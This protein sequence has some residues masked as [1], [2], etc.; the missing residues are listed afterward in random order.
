MNG[1]QAV[2]GSEGPDSGQI[3]GQVEEDPGGG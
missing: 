1:I 2:K 3:C